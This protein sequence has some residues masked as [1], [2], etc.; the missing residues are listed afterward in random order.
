[1][2]SGERRSIARADTDFACEEGKKHEEER[3]LRVSVRTMLTVA[4]F[5]QKRLSKTEEHA[6]EGLSPDNSFRTRAT[7][8]REKVATGMAGRDVVTAIER[9][10]TTPEPN[11]CCGDSAWEST[12]SRGGEA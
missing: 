2:P 4:R 12:S 5:I 7:S 10:A 11:H 8:G 3:L 1:M 6:D 9:T